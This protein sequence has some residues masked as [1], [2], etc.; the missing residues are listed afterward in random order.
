[1]L[2]IPKPGRKDSLGYQT[3][4]VF[5][6][7]TYGLWL[8]VLA[9]IV[10]ASLLSVWF[11]DREMEAKTRFD[12]Q[13]KQSNRRRRKAAYFRLMLDAFLE[14]GM[15]FFSAG[16]EQD[17]GASLPHKVLMFGFGF[18]ILIAV[19]AYVANLA[20]FLTQTGLETSV[21]TMQQVVDRNIPICGHSQLKEDLLLEW[22]KANWVFQS[23]SSYDLGYASML[24]AYA[25][26]DCKVLALGREDTIMD[27]NFISKLC[28]LDLIYTDVLVRENAIAFPIKKEVVSEFNHWM[29]HA[30]LS[31]NTD[32]ESVKQE[33]IEKNDFKAPCEVELSK[34]SKEAQ[35]E[36]NDF[37]SVTPGNMFFP[38][39]LFLG[40]VLIAAVLQL[41]HDSMR[42]KGQA[43]DLGRKS[44]LDIYL[45]SVV[46]RLSSHTRLSTHANNDAG[47][48]EGPKRPS[49]KGVRF[50]GDLPEDNIFG[51]ESNENS[52]PQS[53]SSPGSRPT[54]RGSS[55]DTD[56]C[57]DGGDAAV[58]VEDNDIGHRLKELVESGMID[59]VLD[60]FDFLKL[61]K[62]R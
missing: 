35:Q 41:Y 18:F 6:P 44:T 49:S 12:L 30:Q 61:K 2:I 54:F 11:S 25:R 21:G 46:R 24:E 10:L 34:L 17:T 48:E 39:M 29:Q 5:A 42:K 14:K 51:D 62:D 59:E 26:G 23:D 43:I 33:F 7:F 28:Q 53:Q 27:V 32:L 20:A 38:I 47:G 31:Q 56:K 1:M 13:L 4:K 3:Q 36:D 55:E 50:S 57:N 52:A 15:F 40:C 16:I 45:E 19:S 60:Y 22:P 37:A 9:V 58:N 8:V